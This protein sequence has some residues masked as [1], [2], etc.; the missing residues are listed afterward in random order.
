MEIKMQNT[1]GSENNIK[2]DWTQETLLTKRLAKTIIAFWQESEPE[3]QQKQTEECERN[4]GAWI[5]YDKT[6]VALGTA[7][8]T[9]IAFSP[10]N[11]P[12]YLRLLQQAAAH[13]SKFFNK[14][15]EAAPQVENMVVAQFSPQALM[16]V[17]ERHKLE[18]DD[19]GN[20]QITAEMGKEAEA[21]DAAGAVQ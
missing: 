17:I 6:I 20:Y 3:E 1:T 7:A 18:P 15:V 8:G 21:L 14:N 11:R 5:D 10:E 4:G 12:A 2:T 13:T 19:D 9:V 16:S